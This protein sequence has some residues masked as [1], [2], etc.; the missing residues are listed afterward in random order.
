MP[1][2]RPSR[3]PDLAP[4]PIRPGIEPVRHPIAGLPLPLTP[5]IGREREIAAVAALVRDP[6][7]R[8]VTLTGP[9]G[10]GKTRLAIAAATEVAAD[11]AGGVTFV[12]LATIRDP[13]LVLPAIAQAL[14][15]REDGDRSLVERLATSL[16]GD[17]ALLVLDNLEQVL[18]AAAHLADL[19]AVCPTLTILATSRSRLRVSGEHD[20]PVPPLALPDGRSL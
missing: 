10:V 8:L 16:G 13:A 7:I 2:S 12:P 9:G 6:G 14:G 4:V 1:T 19:L 5:L 3:Q 17:E 11:A 15:I 18:D 20:F